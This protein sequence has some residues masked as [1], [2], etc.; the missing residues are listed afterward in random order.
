MIFPQKWQFTLK[1]EK[2]WNFSE[3]SR[4]LEHENSEIQHF[5]SRYITD[6][7]I[8]FILF[9]ITYQLTC[10]GKSIENQKNMFHGFGVSMSHTAWLGLFSRSMKFF[11][12]F[13]RPSE[14]QNRRFQKQLEKKFSEP[15][16]H[17]RTF[18]RKKFGSTMLS[19]EF[20]GDPKILSS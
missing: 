13:C 9:V 16:G 17:F 10:P 11:F 1:N 3:F 14:V 18:F 15:K 12:I 20:H 19:G 5:S 7:H 4:I 2:I 8:I 6:H